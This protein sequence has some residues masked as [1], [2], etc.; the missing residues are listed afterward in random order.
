MEKILRDDI[1]KE[2]KAHEK[3]SKAAHDHAAAERE[4]QRWREAAPRAMRELTEAA[5]AYDAA[6]QKSDKQRIADQTAIN[7]LDLDYLF[8]LGSLTNVQQ[9]QA[10]IVHS[11]APAVQLQQEFTAVKHLSGAYSEYLLVKQD[12]INVGRA[13]MA[14]MKDEVNAVNDDMLGSIKNLA[15]GAVALTGSQKAAAAFKIGYEIAEGIAC[16][17]S[18]TWPPNPAAI[19]AAGLHFEAAAQYAVSAGRGGASR[20]SVGASAGAGGGSYSGGSGGSG[21]SGWP[22]Q[23]LAPG[24]GGSGG[25]FGPGSGLVMVFGGPDVHAWMAKTVTDATNMGHTVQATVAQRGSPIGH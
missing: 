25:R 4:V 21:G 17:A 7:K 19:V 9:R 5:N 18:G 1:D 15:E 2:A 8:T 13:F 24:A 14:A 23:T 3:N 6:L 11:A 12:A 20:H 16:L 22:N 10:A